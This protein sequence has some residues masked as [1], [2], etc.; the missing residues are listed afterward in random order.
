MADGSSLRRRRQRPTRT[1]DGGSSLRRR[2][3][4]AEAYDDEGDSGLRQRQTTAHSTTTAAAAYIDGRQRQRPTPTTAV[5][6]MTR[7]LTKHN[8]DTGLLHRLPKRNAPVNARW[9]HC[10]AGEISVL[11]TLHA[12]IGTTM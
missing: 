12:L 5:L 9:M 6:I 3:W 7:R 8:A 11:Y 1:A 10:G 4:R 2:R